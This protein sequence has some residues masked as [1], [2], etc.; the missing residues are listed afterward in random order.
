[1]DHWASYR[2][3]WIIIERVTARDM[4]HHQ[5]GCRTR[6]GSS[7]SGL[8]YDGIRLIIEQTTTR[9]M[10]HHQVGYS[11]RYSSSSSELPH[12]IWLI[13]KWVT[14]WD[15]ADH[16]ASRHMRY[17]SSSSGLL[18]EIWTIKRAATWDIDPQQVG[19]R[20]RYGSSLS[21]PPYKIWL[22]I[23]E[24]LLHEI[25]IIIKQV[26][27][28]D[29]VHPWAGHHIGYGSLQVRFATWDIK[30][31]TWDMANYQVSFTTKKF[32]VILCCRFLNR[33]LQQKTI[34]IKIEKSWFFFYSP[35][36]IFFL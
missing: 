4:D 21:R 20:L 31:A 11:M 19:C 6:Y 1:M 30:Q 2:M 12:E 25:W 27:T 15:M 26:T 33:F 22:I 7:S 8:Q 32:K 36:K 16:W 29:L 28:W 23:S 3:I 5:P 18:Y 10:V 34:C 9:D 24:Q 17:G 35:I 13:I 14:A